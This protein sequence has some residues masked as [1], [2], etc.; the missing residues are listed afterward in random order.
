MGGHIR[1]VVVGVAAAAVVL[2]AV[3]YTLNALSGE[4]MMQKFVREV[5]SIY[6]TYTTQHMPPEV[7]SPDDTVVTQWLNSR[8]EYPLNVPGMTDAATQLLGVRLCRLF[9]RK[10]AAVFYKRHGVDILLF[11]FK[12][13]PLA[14]V[15][16]LTE[17]NKDP[18][19][20]QSVGGRPVAMWKRGGITYSMVGDLPRD[21]LRHLAE[22][23]YYR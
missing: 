22:T 16:K 11:A 7:E 10:S 1:D 8:M 4:D 5:S 21:E 15:K 19:H 6:G 20:I 13:E 9:S 18:I 23:M 3:G 17:P 14:V 2:L 12:G